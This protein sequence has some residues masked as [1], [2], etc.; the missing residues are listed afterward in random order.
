MN[1]T[2]SKTKTENFRWF[3]ILIGIFLID[4]IDIDYKFLTFQN[5]N[6][7]FQ[8]GDILRILLRWFEILIGIFLDDNIYVDLTALLDQNKLEHSYQI[9]L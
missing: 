5:D 9:E 4:N 1:F 2:N 8:E 6:R 7:K 3:K